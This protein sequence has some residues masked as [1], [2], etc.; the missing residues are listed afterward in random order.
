MSP[1]ASRHANLAP[2]ITTSATATLGSSRADAFL[3]PVASRRPI[4][5]HTHTR[6]TQAPTFQP[7]SGASL[8]SNNQDRQRTNDASDGCDGQ[9][10]TCRW[11]YLGPSS[12]GL[13]TTATRARESCDLCSGYRSDCTVDLTLWTDWVE[14]RHVHR[15]RS[16]PHY[17]N[18]DH[19]AV[20]APLIIRSTR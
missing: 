16:W 11:C 15:R 6:N 4:A 8:P 17:R 3:V 14:C 13:E 18:C 1:T 7:S 9:D 5:D 19:C 2:I 10:G 20:G 12:H